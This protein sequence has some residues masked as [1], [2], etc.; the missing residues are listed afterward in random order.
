MAQTDISSDL[1]IVD[2]EC[3]TGD[4]ADVDTASSISGLAVSIV[5]DACSAPSS[6]CLQVFD[7]QDCAESGVERR[8]RARGEL[9]YNIHEVLCVCLLLTP[10]HVY[11]DAAAG[12]EGF[13]VFRTRAQTS[14]VE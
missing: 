14:A 1:E 4:D 12:Y 11:A 10:L 2:A 13:V 8:Q 3:A 6:G 9:K 5:S 7:P